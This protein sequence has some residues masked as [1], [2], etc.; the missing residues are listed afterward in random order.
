MIR[1]AIVTA[2][3]RVRPDPHDT[4]AKLKQAIADQA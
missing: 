2:D 4:L 1:H 3:W